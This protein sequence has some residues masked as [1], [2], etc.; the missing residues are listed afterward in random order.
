MEIYFDAFPKTKTKSGP[1]EI[2]FCMTC[3]SEF[4]AGL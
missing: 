3:C 2:D 1:G 4:T